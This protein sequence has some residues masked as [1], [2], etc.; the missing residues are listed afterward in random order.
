MLDCKKQGSNTRLFD[1]QM[2]A[3]RLLKI[4]K[5]CY[6]R[7]LRNRNFKRVTLKK[8]ISI[9]LHVLRENKFLSPVDLKSICPPLVGK[10]M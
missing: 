5:M 3:T 1:D 2:S 10:Q 4:Y 9:G 8:D 7:Y 6:M